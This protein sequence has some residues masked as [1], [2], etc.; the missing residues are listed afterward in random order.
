MTFRELGDVVRFPTDL[1]V[2]SRND[3]IIDHFFAI[4]LLLFW[5]GVD[6]H[7]WCEN[8]STSMTLPPTLEDAFALCPFFFFSFF[9]TTVDDDRKFGFLGIFFQSF[10]HSSGASS[11]P[12]SSFIEFQKICVCVWKS[13]FCVFLWCFSG[14]YSFITTCSIMRERLSLSLFLC[15]S[16]CLLHRNV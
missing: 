12:S 6:D 9:V 3:I 7:R 16:V 8:F 2:L 15:S 13:S 5:G 14:E 1:R 10:S 11:S 4:S